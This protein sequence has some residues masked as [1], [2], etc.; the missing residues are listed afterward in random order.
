VTPPGNQEQCGSCYAF[1]ANGAVESAYFLKTGKL[2]TLS[3]QEVLD[4]STAEGNQ[5]CNGGLNDY[6][7]QYIIKN[8][9][10]ETEKDYPYSATGPNTC[11]FNSSE[12]VATISS[13]VD[14]PPTETALQNA[15]ALTPVANI[16]DASH[17]S[18]QF[19]TGGVYNEPKCSSTQLDH[20]ALVVG[21]GALNGVD[22]W[23]VKN[24][25]GTEWGMKGYIL[26]SRNKSNQCGVATEASYP[27]V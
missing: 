14:V 17:A 1:S 27:V 21:Y 10:I 20:T 16:F 6:V 5:G 2:Y 3:V 26:M 4:C 9:G 15:V 25:W 18:F 13:F 24:S 22:Y 8:K 11:A 19:Y 12:V 23:I 7:F